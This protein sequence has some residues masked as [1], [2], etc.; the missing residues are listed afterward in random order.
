VFSGEY[1]DRDLTL[2][3]ARKLAKVHNIRLPRMGYEVSLG[4]GLWLTASGHHQFGTFTLSPHT[5]PYR[6]HGVPRPSQAPE[7]RPRTWDVH[8]GAPSGH[9]RRAGHISAGVTSGFK[10]PED[11]EAFAAKLRAQHPNMPVFV[12]EAKH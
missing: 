12:L 1:I 3:E 8:E 2:R 11:A 10:S 7:S 6:V 4:N 9:Q 5:K